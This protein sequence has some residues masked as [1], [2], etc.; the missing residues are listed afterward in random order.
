MLTPEQQERLTQIGPGTP[1]GALLRRYWHPVATSAEMAQRPTKIVRILGEELVLFT[2][3]QGRLGLIGRYCAHRR[4]DLVYGMPDERG[5]RCPYHGWCYDPTG[6]C[7]EQPFEDTVHPDGTFK[8]RVKLAGYPV[9]AL[10]GLVFAY[11]GPAPAPVLPRWDLLVQ[12]DLSRE[13]GYTVTRCNWLQTVENVLD[14]VHVEWLHTEFRNYAAQRSGRPE[15]QRRSIRHERIA[16]DVAEYGI[17]KRRLLQGETEEHDDWRVG[18]WLV[19]PN[20]Q[21]GADMMRFRVPIDD[22]RTAQ[23]YY[24]CRPAPEGAPQDPTAIPYYEM[25]SPDLDAH[26]QPQWRLLDGDVDVQDNAIFAGQGPLYD[27]T[28]EMLGESDRGIILYRRL[29]EEQMALVESGA[30]PMNVFRTLPEH[31]VLELPTE[32]L[33]HF[34]SEQLTGPRRIASTAR[35]AYSAKYPSLLP[36][37]LP[38][39]NGH[40]AASEADAEVAARR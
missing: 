11:L 15:R 7:V 20:V 28:Q 21:K 22:T 5:L 31:G 6:Q 1:M 39:T 17:I 30:D 9:Q 8:Q 25:P 33:E 34:L 32:R 19:F 12:T 24:S 35:E 13:I 14:P 36:A 27:R 18:H 3:T 38:E 10:G 37:P 40:Q 2:D 29:L 26:E 16:F 4:A 23:W